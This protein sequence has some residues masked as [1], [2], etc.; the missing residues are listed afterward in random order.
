MIVALPLFRAVS[1]PSRMASKIFV[2]LT[3]VLA[4]F[5]RIETEPGN[6]PARYIGLNG[7]HDAPLR[8]TALSRTQSDALKREENIPDIF[9]FFS[10]V[11]RS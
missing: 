6:G 11:P 5:I 4:G 2:R 10:E 8:L 9:Y 7:I 3:P 1:V